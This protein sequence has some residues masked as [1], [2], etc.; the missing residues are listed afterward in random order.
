MTATA[1]AEPAAVRGGGRRLLL[2][3]AR[4]AAYV[5]ALSFLAYELWGARHGLAGNLRRVGWRN[6]LIAVALLAAGGLPG[7]FGWRILLTRLGTRLPL[8]T[9][10]RLFFLAGLTRYLPGGIWPT[11]THAA[12]ARPLGEP[13][14]RL[15]GALGASQG[16]TVIAGLGVGLLALPRLVAAHAIWWALL[17]VLV[18]ALLPVFAPGLLGRLLR[19]AQRILRGTGPP[20]EMPGRGV[21]LAVAALMGVGW[22]VTGLHIVVLAIALGASPAGTLTVGIG[23]FA[24]SVVAGLFAVL[25]PGGLGVREAVL[26]LTLATLL[27]GPALVTL[28]ILSRVL[29]TAAD[30]A[31]TAVVLGWLAWR[32]RRRPRSLPA[33]ARQPAAQQIAAQQIAAQQ[34]AAQQIAAQQIAAQQIAAQPQPEG[35]TPS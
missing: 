32:T 11:V 4:T 6:A 35:V 33:A 31:S 25:T 27:T 28:I 19:L 20:V 14:A 7:F 9:A 22:L 16:L 2:A 3:A 5:L 17:P 8:P 24:L 13:P 26:A 15:A 1:G 34:A 21:L 18:L 23:G 10:I 29:T 30:L 12:L